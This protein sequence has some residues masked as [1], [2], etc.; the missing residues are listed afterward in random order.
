MHAIAQCQIIAFFDT[1]RTSSNAVSC[2]RLSVPLPLSSPAASAPK[3]FTH[4][5]T[6][7]NIAEEYT[8]N[9]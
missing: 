9:F 7:T 4:T 1:Y 3:T 8:R 2:V 6:H 5:Y